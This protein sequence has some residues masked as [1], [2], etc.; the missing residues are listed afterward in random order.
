MCLIAW[1]WQPHSD[2]PLLLLS[3]RDEFYARP[4]EAL[5]HWPDLPKNTPILAGRDTRA[6]GTWLGVGNGGRLAALT[7]F[8]S[9]NPLNNDAPS[10]GELVADFLRSPQDASAYLQT[11][12]QRASLYNP[13]NLLVYDGRTLLGLESRGAHIVTLQP[14]IGAVSNADFNAPWPKLR[15]LTSGL[16][17]CLKRSETQDQHLWPLLQV[18]TRAADAELP[19]TG[20]SLEL[21]RA[22]SATFITTPDYGT[23][24]CSLVRIEKQG[25]RFS[26]QRFGA[27]G[28]L[29]ETT[30]VSHF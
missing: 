6:G 20:V 8:R 2:T 4:T 23:R 13:F 25:V 27:E 9:P 5:H 29:G 22:L 1:S 17:D 14:G 10:R 11:L 28:V 15:Q 7:N 30:L 19:R 24:A 16:T 3:N 21:E 12:Q 18:R 26:E